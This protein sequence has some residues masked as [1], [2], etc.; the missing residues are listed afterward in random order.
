MPQKVRHGIAV[1]PH[2]STPPHT[3]TPTPPPPP[4]LFNMANVMKMP[5]FRAMGI[6]D[7]KKVWFVVDVVWKSQQVIDD[8][9]KKAQLVTT[10]QDRALSLYI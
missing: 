1:I 9:L 6:E 2:P 3:S 10:L 8:G 7:P 4:P 5:I